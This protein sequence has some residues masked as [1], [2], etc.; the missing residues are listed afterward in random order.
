MSSSC[1][2]SVQRA[3]TRWSQTCAEERPASDGPTAISRSRPSVRA[4]PRRS[5]RPSEKSTS[6]EPGSS[7]T[8]AC[9]RTSPSSPYSGGE[10]ALPSRQGTPSGGRRRMGG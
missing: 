6:K 10:S 3:A 4:S 1:A 9:G 7:L 2:C 8:F 5:T